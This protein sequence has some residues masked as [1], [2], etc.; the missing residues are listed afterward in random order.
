MDPDSLDTGAR[1]VL[2]EVAATLREVRG[3]AGWA[4][5]EWS[6][7]GTQHSGRLW[8]AGDG[9]LRRAQLPDALT[10][11]LARLRVAM[12]DPARGAWLS[13]LVQV[14]ADDAVRLET[15]YFQRPY[16]NSTTDSM[17]DR[18]AG[19]A[20][21]DEARWAAD[22]R[23]YPR[24]REHQ[25]SWLA[26]ES[27]EGEAAAGLRSAL[28]RAGHPRGGVTL[29]GEV[30]DGFEGTIDVV[31]Y[32]ARHYGLQL[33]DYG[34][35]EFLAEFPSEAQACQAAWTYLTTPIPAPTPIGVGELQ[36][37]AQGAQHAYADLHRR[38]V[39]AGPGGIV[40]NLAAGVPFD[41]IGVLDGLY[42]FAWN[43]PWPQRALPDSAHG[44]GAQQIVLMATAPVE[45]QAEIV[46]AWFGQPG[47]GIRFRVQ[48]PGRGIR[49][50]VRGGVLLQVQ[51]VG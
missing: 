40:T 43:T 39:H 23:R 16:W 44:P 7:A 18:P 32:S 33:S 6:Q 42:F 9:E 11:A 12:V 45:A 31:R 19:A 15:N 14:D 34:Q 27:I 47:G 2:D 1:A 51:P 24:D 8:V 36:Q 17:L 26:A 28:D 38:L 46:P 21:P 13:A 48:A 25:L 5:V 35:H 41:R 29:P 4:Q 30:G 20:V 22:L 10:A 49:D 50:L 3:S 37:R